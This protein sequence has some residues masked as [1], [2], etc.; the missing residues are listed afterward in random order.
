MAKI[1]SLVD[2]KP[3][4]F[5]YTV[6]EYDLSTGSWIQK[7]IKSK[8]TH[9][10]VETDNHQ[11]EIQAS[12]ALGWKAMTR[13][14]FEGQMEWFKMKRVEKRY[15]GAYPPPGELLPGAPVHEEE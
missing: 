11:F 14:Q 6:V 5:G 4:D 12:N 3:R 1:R 2:A 8:K 10:R 9:M 13:S 7:V 15:T